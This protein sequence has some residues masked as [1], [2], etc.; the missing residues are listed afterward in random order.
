[1]KMYYESEILRYKSNKVCAEAIGWKPQGSD[2]QS[3]NKWSDGRLNIV[4][5]SGFFA[6]W[7]I[8]SIQSKLKSQLALL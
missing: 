4:R 2:N 7:S 6:V 1:M 3:F 8:D 5:V